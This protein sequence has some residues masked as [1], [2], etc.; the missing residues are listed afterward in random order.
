MEISDKNR[1][2]LVLLVIL[3]V[4]GS[5]M[6]YSLNSESRPGIDVEEGHGEIDL[7][8]MPRLDMG[9]TYQ[10]ETPGN[11]IKMLQR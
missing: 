11:G 6:A 9:K 1:P 5:I 10:N 3:L 7:E 2:R 4:F 8:Y